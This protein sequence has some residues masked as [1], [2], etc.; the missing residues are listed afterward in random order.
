MAFST[1]KDLDIYIYF[2]T[3]VFQLISRVTLAS[4]F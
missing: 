2:G 4:N 3:S 1:F